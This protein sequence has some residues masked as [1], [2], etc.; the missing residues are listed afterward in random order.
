MCVAPVAIGL[1]SIEHRSHSS[2]R[3]VMVSTVPIVKRRIAVSVVE[4]GLAEC[5]LNLFVDGIGN[6][7]R[8]AFTASDATYVGRIDIELDGDAFI[9][10]AKYGERLERRRDIIGLVTI[11]D[12]LVRRSDPLATVTTLTQMVYPLG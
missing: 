12:F 4:T 1:V 5:A 11:H 6:E 7:G 9:D 2:V 10:A 3:V 8:V